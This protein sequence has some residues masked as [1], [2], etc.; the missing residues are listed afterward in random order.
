M[1]VIKVIIMGSLEQTS[2]A[3]AILPSIA[4]AKA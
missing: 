3:K 1:K 4:K 2:P